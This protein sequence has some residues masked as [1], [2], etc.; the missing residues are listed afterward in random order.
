MH[1]DANS[2]P[3]ITPIIIGYW[4]LQNDLFDISFFVQATVS[5]QAKPI[6]GETWEAESLS[7]MHR[8]IYV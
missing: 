1:K 8:S 6:K 7:L 5:D 2:V 3:V 4:F